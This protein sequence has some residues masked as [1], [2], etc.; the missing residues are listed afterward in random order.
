MANTGLS[1]HFRERLGLKPPTPPP[2]LLP[3]KVSG[4]K[5]FM[6]QL[7]QVLHQHL[8]FSVLSPAL[9]GAFTNLNAGLNICYDLIGQLNFRES[10]N[11]FVI[12]KTSFAIFF[13]IISS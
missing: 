3:L 10:W 6:K 12:F 5:R 4:S 9:L 2:A 7:P 13:I 8:A 1:G 11:L